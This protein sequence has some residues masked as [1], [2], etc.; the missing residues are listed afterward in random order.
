LPVESELR[1]DPDFIDLPAVFRAATGFELKD[2]LA[3]GVGVFVWFNEQSYL[4][5]TYSVDRESINPG[6]FLSQSRI[7]RDYGS[8]LLAC[9][10]HTYD[11]ALAAIQARPG[12]PASAPFDFRPFMGAPAVRRP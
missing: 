12:A 7:D 2:Y 6:T 3:F 9:F 11:T 10:T 1:S 8:R 5:N 4:R